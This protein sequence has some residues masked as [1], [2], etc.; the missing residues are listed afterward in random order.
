M[1]MPGSNNT[2]FRTYPD[3][4][5]VAPYGTF[6]IDL[7]RPED[8]VWKEVSEAYRKDIRRAIKTGVQI[9][10]GVEYHD[11]AYTLVADT[12]NRSGVKH[13]RKYEDFKASVLA[14]GEN[15]KVLVAVHDGIVQ[16]SLFTP[17]SEYSAY[18]QYGGTV[19]QPVRGAM[20]LLHW[21]A[22]RRFH[23]MGVKR[24]NFTGVRI[25]PKKGS[26]QDGILTFKRRFGGSLIQGY[27][28][29]YS[30]S[31]LKFAAYS[32]SVR[33]LFGGDIVDVERHKLATH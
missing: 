16:A 10:E 31:F 28:W 9:K 19:A 21:E 5:A 30:F 2:L 15:V 27:M 26:K 20:H 8:V 12:L 22:I 14:L 3:G 13:K 17:F 11:A 6:V 23:A 25:D 29:K 32:A 4:A 33:L 24:F 1:I 7:N 18:S